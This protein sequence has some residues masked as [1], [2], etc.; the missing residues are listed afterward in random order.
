[1][2]L[3]IFDDNTV[4]YDDSHHRR[5]N[6]SLDTNPT[7]NKLGDILVRHVFRRNRIGDKDR[8]GNPLIY[9]LKEMNGY[10]IDENERIKFF[11]RAA[12]IIE[13]FTDDLQADFVMPL[14][15]SKP[16]CDDFA[17]LV[18]GVSGI[19]YLA[20]EF[21]T[22]KT[23]A[24]A[25]EQYGDQVPDTLNN[26]SSKKYKSELKAWRKLGGD[27]TLSMKKIDPSIRRCFNPFLIE[28]MTPELKGCRIVLVDDLMS[29]G[30]SLLSV[31]FLLKSKE[32]TANQGVCF[33]SGL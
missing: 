1:M 11:D 3:N 23:I 9:A 31:S 8:D 12:Q 13:T 32:C 24:H 10:R 28:N 6:T 16:F 29:S 15:S 4:G 22:K 19:E 7:Q 21:L 30:A 18:C 2:G 27:E 14:P 17:R 25:L 33:L 20:P 5:V 26:Y